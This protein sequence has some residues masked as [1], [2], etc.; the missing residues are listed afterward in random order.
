LALLPLLGVVLLPGTAG[1]TYVAEPPD[2]FTNIIQQELNRVG[3]DADDTVAALQNWYAQSRFKPL[4]IGPE[5]ANEK[6]RQFLEIL[7]QADREGLDPDDYRADEI[8]QHIAASPA[9]G[10]LLLSDAFVRYVSDLR[11]GRLS[12]RSVDP[13]LFLDPAEVNSNAI[14]QAAR[15]TV[16]ILKTIEAFTPTNPIYRQLRRV[17]EE[18]REIEL[19]GG[20]PLVPEGSS[21]KPGMRDWRVP[22]LRCRLMATKDLPDEDGDS[23]FYDEALQQ[24]VL[25]FQRRHG[26]V[27]DGVV[28]RRTLAELNVPVERRIE[29]IIVNMERSRWLPDELGDRY[30]LVNIAGYELA[31]VE[32]GSVAM[33]MKTIIGKPYR[34]TPVFSGLMTYM[35]FNPSW[36]VPPTIVKHDILPKVRADS[37]YLERRNMRVFLGWDEKSA[38]LAASAVDWNAI[39]PERIPYRFRQEPGPANALGRVKFILPN[40]FDVYLHDTPKRALFNRTV[41]SFSSGCVRVEDPLG[42]AEFLTTDQPGWNRKRIEEIIDSRKTRVVMLAKPVPVHLTYSTVWLDG[43][44]TI[45]FRDDVYARDDLMYQALF[46]YPA[47]RKQVPQDR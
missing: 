39:D 18:Y 38:E 22:I 10:E 46:G 29:Q 13:A 2:P 6:A 19:D 25:R 23:E 31:V 12:P 37:A 1:A 24:A 43:D 15:N 40:R 11:N 45:Q 5:G 4:W 32:S 14:L 8:G 30:I 35:E 33:T 7:G 28:G 47:A 3:S 21:L 41:R 16:D 9:D 17:L 44:G 20:W 42:L 26:L 36:T 34:R 27:A